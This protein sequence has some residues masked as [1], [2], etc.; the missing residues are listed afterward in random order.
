MR[1]A[2]NLWYSC[3]PTLTLGLSKK[4]LLNMR[5]DNR[6]IERIQLNPGNTGNKLNA[7]DVNISGVRICS[8]LNCGHQLRIHVPILSF[9]SHILRLEASIYK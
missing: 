1:L 6:R 5:S 7:T 9:L 2:A 8:S 3:P 4:I